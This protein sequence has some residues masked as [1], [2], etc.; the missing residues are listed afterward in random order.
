MDPFFPATGCVLP[1]QVLRFH[2]IL[3]DSSSFLFETAPAG[4]ADWFEAFAC[5]SAP[6]RRKRTMKLARS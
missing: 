4:S 5:V 2:V 3:Q 6:A 1:G